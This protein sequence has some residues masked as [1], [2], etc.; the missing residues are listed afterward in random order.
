M[1]HAVE[2]HVL[3]GDSER[4]QPKTKGAKLCQRDQNA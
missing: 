3:F 1:P 2:R 4:I